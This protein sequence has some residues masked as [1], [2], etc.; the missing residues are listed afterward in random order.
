MEK[1]K[2]II[3]LLTVALLI[4]TIAVH[5]DG[6]VFGKEINE[7]IS[8]STQKAAGPT[9]WIAEDG[10]RLISSINI[11]QDISGFAGPTPVLLTI[12]NGKIVDIEALKN[13]ETPEFLHSALE[14]GLLHQWNGLSIEEALDVEADAVS[15][16]TMSSTAFIK[17]IRR[18]LEYAASIE[19]QADLEWLNW[20]TIAS[21]LVILSGVTSSL[22]KLKSKRWRLAQL[23]LNV[24]VLGFWCGSFLSISLLTNWLANGINFSFALLTVCLLFIAIVMP[25]LG[26]KTRT[27]HGIAQWAHS[28]NLPEK[29]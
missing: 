14:N 28:K 21:F 27:A 13:S 2:Y 23:I 12:Y 24:V 25:L 7:L 10:S 5:R 16:A 1:I 3:K 19:P 9:E 18:T 29:P 17:T 6:K 20:K 4:S 8:P 22:F 11:A 15:G 26:R